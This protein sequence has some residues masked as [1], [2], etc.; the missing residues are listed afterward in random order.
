LDPEEAEIVAS[1]TRCIAV[2]I[3]LIEKVQAGG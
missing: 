1:D 2:L 3:V